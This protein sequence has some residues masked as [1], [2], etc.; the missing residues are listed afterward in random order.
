MGW[1]FPWVSSGNTSFNFDFDVS[2]SQEAVDQKRAPYNY[3]EMPFPLV[4]APGFSA[5]LRDGDDVFHSYSTF[6]RGVD[7]LM[8]VYNL[9]DLTPL[10]RQ[11]DGKGMSWLRRHDEY[12]LRKPS[13]GPSAS[14]AWR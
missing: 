1:T 7:A 3:K 8:N 4:E 5:F 13:F 10:G 6:E 14:S 11:E 9:L 12:G 2:F